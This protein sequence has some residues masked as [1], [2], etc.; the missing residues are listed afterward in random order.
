MKVIDD[1]YNPQFGARPIDR[2]LYGELEEKLI[3]QVMEKEMGTK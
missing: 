1:I 3:Q 2:Y